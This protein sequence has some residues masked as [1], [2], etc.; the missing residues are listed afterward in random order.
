[1]QRE[2]TRRKPNHPEENSLIGGGRGGVGEQL[3]NL[4]IE[5]D[6]GD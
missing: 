4:V 6:I 2:E 3:Q 1:M 5:G